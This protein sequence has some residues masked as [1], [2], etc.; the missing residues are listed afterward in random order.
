MFGLSQKSVEE[1]NG[2]FAK[3]EGIDLVIVYGS[4][5]KGNYKPGS[6]IDFAIKGQLSISEL[7]QLE[8]ELDDLLLPYTI[9]I[10]LI[11]RINE[12]ALI[13]HIE[14]VGKIFYNRLT[15]VQFNEDPVPYIKE[16]NK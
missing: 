8:S 6:D 4:R 3:Y 13:N 1:I 5:A 7:L 15:P 16:I 14:R 9:D 11:D 12:P 10:S 2:C